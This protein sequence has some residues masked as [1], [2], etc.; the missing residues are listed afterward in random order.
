MSIEKFFSPE[1]IAVVGASRTT[2]KVGNTV[3]KNLKD[4][5]Q[6]K[7]F[8]VNPK[9]D[10]VA[11]LKCFE[12]LKD[13][14][15]VPEGVVVA[16]PAK[17]ANKVVKTCVDMEV[18]AVTLLTSGYGETGEKGEELQKELEETIKGSETRLIGPNCLGIWDGRNGMDTMFL[19]GY[20]LETPPEGNIAVISQSGAVGSALLDIAA[21]RK[22][23]IS[24]FVSY[25][26][27][28]DV[29]ET[30]LLEF[31][32]D[33]DDTDAIAV[34]M[35][36]VKN[37][38]NFLEKAGKVTQDTPVVV[39]KAGKTEEGSK[40]AVSHTGSM[41]GNYQVY[42]GAF[43]QKN[44]VEA[45]DSGELFDLVKTLAKEETPDGRKVGIV[46]NGGGFGVLA[47]DQVSKTELELAE[48]SE[49]TR[50]KLEDK[51]K[52]YGTVSNP[53][54]V[55]GDAGPEMYREALEAFKKDPEIDMILCIVLM[56][57]GTMRSEVVE[58]LEDTDRTTEK[59]VVG[60]MMGGDYTKLH[61]DYLEEK[62]VPMFH[63]PENAVKAL[64]SLREYGDR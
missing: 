36:G 11:G 27:Q 19:P 59:P 50:E 40:A 37:S 5:F 1:S 45:R 26:N 10:K 7:I 46:T 48:F 9:A 8:P 64:E 47:T 31:L 17:I 61:T 4:S 28:L 15:E 55:I 49:K 25:G 42:Q 32:G 6:G 16:V 34:Y 63:R 53:L 14:G 18:P 62:G 43:R 39:L 33:D 60:C 35:E 29:S 23:G 24:K 30:D 21:H 56:Q 3:V 44:V 38:R 58:I 12:S 13:I 52:S 20:K 41:A 22:I 54:D 2:G 57:T 51:M